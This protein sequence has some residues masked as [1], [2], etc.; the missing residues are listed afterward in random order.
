M[1]YTYELKQ[2]IKRVETAGPGHLAEKKGWEFP[3]MNH[4][5]EENRLRMFHPSYKEGP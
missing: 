3:R 2:L 5:G 1:S 4:A